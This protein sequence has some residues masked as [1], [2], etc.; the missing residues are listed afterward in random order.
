VTNQEAMPHY[1]QR[2]DS[3]CVTVARLKISLHDKIGHNC[4][5]KKRSGTGGRGG[6]K[7]H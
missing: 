7:S 5:L 6:E 3:V 2:F 4:G 1:P